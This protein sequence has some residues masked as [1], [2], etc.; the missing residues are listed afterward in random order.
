VGKLPSF[1]F[2]R[3]REIEIEIEIE[4]ETST[5]GGGDRE[6]PRSATNHFSFSFNQMLSYC[7]EIVLVRWRVA[8]RGNIYDE[9]EDE[10]IGLVTWFRYQN[11]AFSFLLLRSDG[12][13]VLLSNSG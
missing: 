12:S 13:V 1:G 2:E 11:C 8:K 6:P 5:V 10:G 3:E 4:I 9:D 7:W